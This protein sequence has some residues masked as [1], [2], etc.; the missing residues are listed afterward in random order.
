MKMIRS[1]T[2]L[3]DHFADI[4]KTVHETGRPVFLTQ[5]GYCDMVV[6]SMEAYENLLCDSEVYSKLQQA[7]QEAMLTRERYSS[8]EVL[9]AMRDAIDPRSASINSKMI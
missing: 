5:N 8:E 9:A 7:E 1:V 4:S 2:D 3:Q 6:L